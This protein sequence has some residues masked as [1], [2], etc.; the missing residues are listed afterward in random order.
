MSER[1]AAFL[2]DSRMSGLPA[3]LV[4]EA[5]LNSGFMVAQVTAAALASENKAL[6][7]PGSL[8]SIPTAANQEDYVSMATFAARRLGEMADNLR[9]ILA[10]ELLAAAQGLHLRRPARTSGPL[11]A[12]VDRL[13]ERVEPWGDD[14]FFAPDVAAAAALIEQP[15]PPDL[16]SPAGLEPLGVSSLREGGAPES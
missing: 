9:D 8:D 12:I 5:G 11:G 7:H 1:R 2:V 6:A 3:F 16:F 10:I 13:R 4:A 14:R 15:D